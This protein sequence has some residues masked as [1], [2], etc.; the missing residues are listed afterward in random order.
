MTTALKRRTVVALLV[1]ALA[2]WV[3]H[4]RSALGTQDSTALESQASQK[5]GVMQVQYLE[6]VT[7]DVEATCSA[8]SKLHEVT[9]GEPV[10]EFGN[11]RTAKLA[12]GGQIGVRAPMH[13]TEVPVTRPYLLVSDIEAAITEAQA[14][15][16]EFMMTTTEI[17]GG[18]GKFAIYHLGGIQYGLWEL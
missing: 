2:L 3:H 8:L 17:P 5:E 14:A 1:P 10:P 4:S 9:F 18:R 11:A 15:G 6:I 16:G 12:N 7:P 13:E